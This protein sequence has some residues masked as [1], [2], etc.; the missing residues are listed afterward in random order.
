M[1]LNPL[2]KKTFFFTILREAWRK[3]SWKKMKIS[4][5]KKKKKKK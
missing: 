2:I 1:F 5:K 3:K 4:K